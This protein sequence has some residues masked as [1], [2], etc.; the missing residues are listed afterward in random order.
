MQETVIFRCSVSHVLQGLLE[1][2]T[3]ELRGAADRNAATIADFDASITLRE[4]LG[5]GPVSGHGEPKPQHVPAPVR[6]R[7]V[8]E[9]RAI[10]EQA[11]VV[12]ELHVSALEPHAEVQA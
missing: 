11:V 4:I 5:Q 8:N 9:T 6:L 12:D 7:P 10:V 3:R 1:A 2:N